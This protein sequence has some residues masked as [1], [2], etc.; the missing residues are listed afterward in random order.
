MTCLGYVVICKE[1]CLR[2]YWWLNKNR[3]WIRE[4]RWWMRKVLYFGWA[5]IC[6]LDR[7][8][9]TLKETKVIASSLR[10]CLKMRKVLAKKVLMY[11][12]YIRAYIGR[13]ITRAITSISEFI[14]G[15][16][17]IWWLWIIFVS[18]LEDLNF[19]CKW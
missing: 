4:L 7:R 12:G 14:R 1:F 3:F 18:K 17:V 6:M 8:S 13:L 16:S 9:V 11:I 5:T 19:Q 15:V 2:W 10:F